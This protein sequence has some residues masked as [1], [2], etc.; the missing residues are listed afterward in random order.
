MTLH[1]L[2][3]N[4]LA[5]HGRMSYDAA[6]DRYAELGVDADAAIERALATPLSVHCWQADDVVGL[7][8]HEGAMDG[9]GIQATGN[10]PGRAR[11]G[12]EIRADFEKAAFKPEV[13]PLILKENAIRL[14]GLDRPA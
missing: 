1:D 13:R 10:Y 11:S 8:V 4:E 5:G 14:L 2:L 7:E 12:D 9:G 3:S 6:R